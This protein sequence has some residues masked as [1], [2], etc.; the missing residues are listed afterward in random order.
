MHTIPVCIGPVPR[1][2]PLRLWGISPS[3]HPS[4]PAPKASPKKPKT[5]SPVRF[6]ENLPSSRVSPFPPRPAYPITHGNGNGNPPPHLS[7]ALLPLP[8]HPTTRMPPCKPSIRLPSSPCSAALWNL[9]NPR[10][11]RVLLRN[12]VDLC[13]QSNADRNFA[14]P[15]HPFTTPGAPPPL[16]SG[17]V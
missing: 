8:S 13:P 16:Q 10:R 2:R 6:A 3:I 17:P 1:P 4:H 7:R 11:A 14:R 5:H 15:Q 9:D 12:H